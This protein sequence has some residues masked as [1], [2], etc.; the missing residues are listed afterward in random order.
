MAGIEALKGAVSVAISFPFQAAR[1][2]KGKFKIWDILA[3]ADELKELSVVISNRSSVAEEFK[4]LTLEE[5]VEII[6]YA[7]DEFDIP[8]EKVEI[9]VENAL[10]WVDATVTLIGEAKKLKK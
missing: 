2:I 10:M 6:Q 7:K 8:D 4:D 5:R 1:T 9:F 3:F